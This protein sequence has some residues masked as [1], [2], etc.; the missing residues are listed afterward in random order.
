[1]AALTRVKG[2]TVVA[3]SKRKRMIVIL[4]AVTG[5]IP[6]INDIRSSN[7]RGSSGSRS[8]SRSSKRNSSSRSGNRN[9][10]NC[11]SIS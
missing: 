4:V 9:D 7:R 2:V 1:M 8:N 6:I 11:S 3:K 5:V 10:C